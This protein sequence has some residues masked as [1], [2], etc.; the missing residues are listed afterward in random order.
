MYIYSVLINPL[1]AH[2]IHINLNT[3]FDTHLE[4]SS[5]NAIY[6]KYYSKKK[7]KKKK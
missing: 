3:V 5:T 7:E 4:Q 1:I 2:M 6:M